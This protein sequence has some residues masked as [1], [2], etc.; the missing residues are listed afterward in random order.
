MLESGEKLQKLLTLLITWAVLL[1]FFFAYDGHFVKGQREYLHERGFRVLALLSNEL[2]A[3]VRQAQSTTKSFSKILAAT[4]KEGPGQSVRS[5]Q[6][7]TM[8]HPIVL[9][10]LEKNTWKSISTSLRLL[11][12]HSRPRRTVRAINLTFRLN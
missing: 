6:L 10:T 5:D 7:P 11:T 4:T 12:N 1:A 2:N 3:K 8:H 9:S